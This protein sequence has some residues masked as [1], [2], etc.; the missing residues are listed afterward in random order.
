MSYSL[1]TK[2]YKRFELRPAAAAADP[3]AFEGAKLAAKAL[4]G[5][6]VN[7]ED[8][9]VVLV[10]RAKHPIL[11]G[12]IELSSKVKYGFTSHKAPIYLFTPFNEA[13]PPF[14]VGC[15]ERDTSKNRLALVEF[16]SWTETF[17]RGHLVRLLAPDADEEALSWTY[18]PAAC[19]A[20]KGPMPEAVAA[21]TVVRKPTPP[22]TFH[23]DPA[24]C[25]DVDDVIS[26]YEV[27]GMVRMVITIADVAAAVPEGSPLDLRAAAIAQTFY[28]DGNKP[29]H[30]FP[31]ELSE[32][33][34]SLL[35]SAEAKLGVSLDLD[36][37][38]P[39]DNKWYLS[40]VKTAETFTYESVYADPYICK[41]LGWLSFRLGETTE[42]R[43]TEDSHKWIE[44]AM[45]F[46]NMEAA[47]LLKKHGQGLLRAHTEPDYNKLSAY[48]SIC[49]DLKFLAYSSA[50]YLPATDDA[51]FHWGVGMQLYTHITS[52]IRRYA[53]LVNQ[54]ALKKI[55]L[56]STASSQETVAALANHLN[57][58][59]KRAKQ[60]DRDLTLLR[61]LKANTS[62]T[63]A[64]TVMEI[65][66]LPT[67]EVKL[68]LYN[69]EWQMLVRLRYTLAEDGSL[70]SKDEKTAYRV[71]VGNKVQLKYYADTR[72]RSWKKRMVLSLDSNRQV[73]YQSL[74]LSQ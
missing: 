71:A 70:V 53:D 18:T 64:A 50:Y 3:V 30:M 66:P 73:N 2:D 58:V 74:P 21:E 27:D 7:Y 25:R 31:P 16:A 65:R 4:P 5:D 36:V 63:T 57:V 23:I 34:L 26:I 44:L 14:V 17:P 41:H 22:K 38:N 12:L 24:G 19:V 20:Y 46:Y 56:S 59:A 67:G 15:S 29:R 9:Q 61:A 72:A 54:R 60:H 39:D 11:A 42:D 68:V 47:K 6:L 1:S 55:I 49:P 52:P 13:Y 28:Q 32:G 45:K 37:N 40:E 51:T 33:Q 48:T 62:G 8:G 35:P 69:H 10:S 43:T